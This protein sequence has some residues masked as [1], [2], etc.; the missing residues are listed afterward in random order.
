MKLFTLFLYFFSF[1]GFVSCTDS[2]L[3]VEGQDR[4]LKE[5]KRIVSPD[6]KVDAVLVETF[7]GATVANGYKIFVVLPGRK[8]ADEE[9]HYSRFTADHTRNLDI[10][11]TQEKRLLISYDKARIFQFTNFWHSDSLDKWDYIVELTL[12]SNKANGQL[13]D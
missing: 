11:W 9:S 2:S 12:K 10:K 5:V 13:D 4:S 3:N 1:L 6:N 7:G 8:I